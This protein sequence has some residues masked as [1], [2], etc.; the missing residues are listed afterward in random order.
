[1]M[2]NARQ[3]FW[4]GAR[5]PIGYRVVEAGQRGAKIKKTLEIDPLQAETVRMVYRWAARGDGQ[6][7]PMGLKSIVT[8]LNDSNIRTRDG[9]RWGI[10]ALHKILTRTT[11]IGEHRFNTHDHNTKQPK[12]E[13]EHAVMAVPPIISRDEFDAVRA[14]LTA[15]NPKW[16]PPGVSCGPN[17]LTG[18][19]FCGTCGGAMTLRTGRGA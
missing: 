6:S 11:Y 3:G 13:S 12:P 10:G 14:K 17:L 16:T 7:G 19:C 8:K 9:G 15:R 18:I 5:P 1:M 4:N 2:E